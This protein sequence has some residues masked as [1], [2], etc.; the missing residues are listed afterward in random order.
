[1]QFQQG[2]NR[3]PTDRRIALEANALQLMPFESLI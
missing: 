1:M 2:G 3:A